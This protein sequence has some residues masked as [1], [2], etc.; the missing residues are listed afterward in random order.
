MSFPERAYLTVGPLSSVDAPRWGKT[1][2]DSRAEI[3]PGERT[4]AEAGTGRTA[5][6]QPGD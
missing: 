3:E 5:G 6:A 4:V 1:K 2:A